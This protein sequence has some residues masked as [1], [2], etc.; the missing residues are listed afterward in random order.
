VNAACEAFEIVKAIEQA[1]FG[2]RSHFF[3]KDNNM[4][5]VQSD[6]E[7]EDP[8]GEEFLQGEHGFKITQGVLGIIE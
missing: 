4:S 1:R 6:Q 7:D 3:R 2:S 5:P 8:A